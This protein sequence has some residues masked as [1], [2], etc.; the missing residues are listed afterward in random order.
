MLRSLTTA[1]A[2]LLLISCRGGEAPPAEPRDSAGQVVAPILATPDAV[3]P[4]SYARPLEARVANIDLDLALDFDAKRVNGVAGLD[5]V[6][7]PTARQLVLDTKGLQINSIV[8]AGGKPLTWKL[9]PADPDKGAPLTVTLPSGGKQRII[10]NY[11]SAP[12]AAA[13]QWLTPEQTAGKRHP[14]LLSQ[15]QPIL[16]RSW[17]PTQDSPGIRQTWEA[18]ITAPEPLKV[19][20]SGD[21]LTPEGEPT[22]NGRRAFRFRMGHPV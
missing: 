4:H 10:I 6:A 19:V 2:A 13:L 8:A 12:D 15:G 21:R 7:A 1:F 11:R 18:R 20:M 14:Y 17:I 22:G 5:I 16:N 9:G 3:D